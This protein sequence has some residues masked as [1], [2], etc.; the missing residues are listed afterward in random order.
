MTSWNM[1]NHMGKSYK[2]SPFLVGFPSQTCKFEDIL[3]EVK[4]LC[5]RIAEQH[6]FSTKV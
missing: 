3:K 4:K 6:A 5:G 2:V 1:Q